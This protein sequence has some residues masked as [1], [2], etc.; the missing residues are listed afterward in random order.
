[1]KITHEYLNTE[2]E[3]GFLF[4]YSTVVLS[5]CENSRRGWVSKNGIYKFVQKI[6][7]RKVSCFG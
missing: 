6:H 3:N 4:Y 7:S 5:M 2:L 1:M